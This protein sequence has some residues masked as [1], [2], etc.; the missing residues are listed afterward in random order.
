MIRPMSD[1]RYQYSTHYVN[2]EMKQQVGLTNNKPTCNDLLSTAFY[3]HD[4]RSSIFLQTTQ[5]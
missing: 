3:L 1:T 5:L 2:K 4:A